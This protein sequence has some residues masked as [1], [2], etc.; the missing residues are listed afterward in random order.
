[1]RAIVL[2]TGS[3]VGIE[4]EFDALDPSQLVLQKPVRGADLGQLI[5]KLKERGSDSRVSG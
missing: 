3:A 5:Q 2:M 4:A 1:M